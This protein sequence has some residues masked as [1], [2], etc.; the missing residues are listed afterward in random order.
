M[1]ENVIGVSGKN[2]GIHWDTSKPN[3]DM[4]RKMDNQRQFELGLYPRTTFIDALNK[5]YTHYLNS[6]KLI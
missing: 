5:T 2:L 1:I 4:N 6:V 3:G